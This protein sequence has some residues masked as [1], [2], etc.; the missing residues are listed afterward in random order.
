M[1]PQMLSASFVV[2]LYS[3]V[4]AQEKFTTIKDLNGDWQTYDESGYM[5][6]TD[7]PFTGLHTIY[8]Q[9]DRGAFP[10]N[11]LLLKSDKPFFVFING[12]IM[13]EYQGQ[14]ILS[15]DSISREID[16]PSYW[17]GVHQKDINERDMRTEIISTRLGRAPED[18]NAA[19][20]YSYFRD[21]VVI[22][23]L[24]TTLLFLLVFRLHPKLAADYFSV[25]RIF[26]SREV[27]D[28]QTS[29]RLTSSS[30]IQFYILCSLLIGLYLLIVFYNLPPKYALPIRFQA[31]G[32]WMICWQWL[33]ISATVFFILVMKIMIIFSL[34]RLFGLRGMA[35]FHF[36]NWIR[37]LLVIFGTATILL[38]MYFISRGDRPDIFVF[39]LSLVVITLIAWIV[40]AFLKLSGRTGHSMFHL[41]SYLCATE[42]IPLLITAKVLFQ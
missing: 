1:W 27:D 17:I 37:L 12:K 40:V 30:N 19:R 28:G 2:F 16:S 33:K 18:A 15:I 38:F 9:L 32:F 3:S 29:I 10:G 23:G 41:F 31:S 11:F 26:S 5:A 25:A 34:T 8:F 42:I 20:P 6:L 13:A 36:F 4:F 7:I 22:A 21:F 14:V 39:F 24:T 35:R